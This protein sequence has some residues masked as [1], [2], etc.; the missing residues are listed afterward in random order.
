[1]AVALDGSTDDHAGYDWSE[2]KK[3]KGVFVDWTEWKLRDV[4]VR[5]GC[6]LALVFDYLLDEIGVEW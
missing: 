3:M 6:N 5:F 1:M 4:G 2:W